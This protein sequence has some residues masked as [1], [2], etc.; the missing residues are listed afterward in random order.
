[1]KGTRSACAC[2]THGITG[3]ESE[4]CITGRREEWMAGEKRVNAD[5]VPEDR[6]DDD[7]ECREEEGGEH[8]AFPAYDARHEKWDPEKEK[9]KTRSPDPGIHSFYLLLILFVCESACTADPGPETQ[10]KLFSFVYHS[11]HLFP[12]L[13]L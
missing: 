13:H 3:K 1:M 10:V 2:V 4:G 9:I 12:R 5:V 8:Q 7:D 6:G 11:L